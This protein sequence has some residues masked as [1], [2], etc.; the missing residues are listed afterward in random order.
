MALGK[1]IIS[2]LLAAVVVRIGQNLRM[3]LTGARAEIVNSRAHIAW[4]LAV[5]FFIY[6]ALSK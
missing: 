1:V 2:I 3:K 5:A 6:A 4:I